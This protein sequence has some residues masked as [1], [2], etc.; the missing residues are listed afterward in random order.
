MKMHGQKKTGIQMYLSMYT[1]THREKTTI[2]HD[3]L[4][5]QFPPCK[6]PAIRIYFAETSLKKIL[7]DNMRIYISADNIYTFK[8]KDF[9]GYDPETYTNGL[10]AFQYPS[11]RTFLA[12]ITL[13]F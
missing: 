6:E 9:V 5:R 4:Q 11:T 2:L 1:E 8:A 12:G 3:S 10:I 13:G 7:I